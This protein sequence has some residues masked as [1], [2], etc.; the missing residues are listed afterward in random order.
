MRLWKM[1][2][3]KGHD[4]KAFGVYNDDDKDDILFSIINILL[5]SNYMH[6]YI[7][8]IQSLFQIII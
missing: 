8:S 6:M 4:Y 3:I 1:W 5:I 2:E 7:I